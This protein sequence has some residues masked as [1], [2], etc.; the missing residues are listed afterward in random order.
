MTGAVVRALDAAP[1]LAALG[2]ARPAAAAVR[3]LDDV[4][5]RL[6]ARESYA[7]GLGAWRQ[8]PRPG[9]RRGWRADRRGIRGERRPDRT[10]V[11]GRR[12]VA[13]ARAV[14]RARGSPGFGARVPAAAR[15]RVPNRRGRTAAE[16]RRGAG[17]TAALPV[18]SPASAGVTCGWHDVDAGRSDVHALRDVTLA[19]EPG[20]AGGGGRAERSGKV[21]ARSSR[22]G[23]PA[24]LRLRSAERRGDEQVRRRR[25]AGARRHAHPAGAHLRHVDRRQRA[26]RKPDGRR[27]ALGRGARAGATG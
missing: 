16:S 23:I 9:T 3:G 14:R 5:T 2:A 25:R 20:A 6:S 19:V 13:A 27:V 1:E 21:N 11:A 24:V 15:I 18:A 22:D 26:D 17:G 12:R 8:R 10:G 4:L 7:L